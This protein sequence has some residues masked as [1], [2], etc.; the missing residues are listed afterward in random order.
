MTAAI[1]AI[2][3]YDM[4]ERRM[5]SKKVTNGDKFISLSN[6][7]QALYF[8]L[9]MNADDDGFCDEIS[10]CMFRSH[11]GTQDFESLIKSGYIYQFESGVI[12]ITDWETNNLIRKDRYTETIFTE[13]KDQYKELTSNHRLTTGQPS[14]NHRSPQDRLG[15]DRLIN[16][17]NS[18]E[19]D[20]KKEFKDPVTNEALNEIMKAWNNLQSKGIPSIRKITGN[21]KRMLKARIREYSVD[22]VK[23]AIDNISRSDFLAGKSDSGWTITFDWFLRPSC[24][25]KV[26]EGNYTNK[27]AVS[28]RPARSGNRQHFEGE[29]AY[30]M[31]DLEKQLFNKQNG[32]TNTGEQP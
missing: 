26:L 32:I 22:Q 13:E 28:T 19:L 30:N 21:R 24:F 17:S 29:R 8:H 25:T 31:T 27:A 20:C 12:V 16:I 23:E 2:K 7:A 11:A 5:F 6:G 9:A 10:I 15:K 18:N 14:V 3:V 4:A 1:R